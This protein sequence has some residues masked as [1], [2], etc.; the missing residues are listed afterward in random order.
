[1]QERLTADLALEKRRSMLRCSAGSLALDELLL[2]GI[3]TQAV[4]EFY[5]EFWEIAAYCKR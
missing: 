1:M 2:G 4:T 3:E 5:G